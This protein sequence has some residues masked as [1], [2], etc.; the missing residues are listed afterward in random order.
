MKRATRH[1]VFIVAR[2][3]SILTSLEGFVIM[4]AATE[5][6]TSLDTKCFVIQFIVGLIIFMSGVGYYKA[7]RY[8]ELYKMEKERKVRRSYVKYQ[9][10]PDRCND[11]GA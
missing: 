8:M 2:G 4:W 3:I 5:T 10:K 7:F 9:I 11:C 6:E 1:K